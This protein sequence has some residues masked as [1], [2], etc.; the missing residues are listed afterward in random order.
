M[1]VFVEFP[2]W[3]YHPTKEPVVV[4]NADQEQAL[5]KDWF[6][7]PDLAQEAL[8]KVQAALA[9]AKHDST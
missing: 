7:R 4:D 6:D 2:K 1:Y 8:T 5:G 3:K 9:K